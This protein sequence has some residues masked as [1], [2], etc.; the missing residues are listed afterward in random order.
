[1]P[2]FG[3][4]RSLHIAVGISLIGLCLLLGWD[5]VHADWS[6]VAGESS[7]IS[8]FIV[9]DSWHAAIVLNR[10]D[11]A[12]DALP[13][14]SDFPDAK[15]IE[16]SWGDKDYFPHPDAGIWAALRAA[17]WS[18]GSVL[19]LVGFNDKV[20]H[21]YRG[22]ANT[23]LRLAPEAFTR[24][25][26]FLS[27]SFA[28]PKPNIRAPGGPGLFTYSRF[29]PANGQFSLLRTCNTWVA[30]ALAAAGMPLSP[31]LVITAANLAGQLAPYGNQQ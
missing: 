17:F 11:I 9:H 24:L 6:C 27:Q 3:A 21:F 29:Y 4:I 25:I 20:E 15:F 13:E 10:S 16:F 30:E 18:G 5:V 28:R 23:E 2:R 14:V 1:M 22:A 26:G 12:A 31:H 8:V 19:H 7:C